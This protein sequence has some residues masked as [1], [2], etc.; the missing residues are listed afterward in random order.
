M[1][2]VAA[3]LNAEMMRALALPLPAPGLNKAEPKC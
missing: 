1:E 2:R 3:A